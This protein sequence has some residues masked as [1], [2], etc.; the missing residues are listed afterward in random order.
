VLTGE[1]ASLARELHASGG[2][3]VAGIAR[4]LGISRSTLYRYLE[5]RELASSWRLTRATV[6]HQRLVLACD[7]SRVGQCSVMPTYSSTSRWS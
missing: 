2:Y 5:V 1:Q 3:S 6:G 7:R 4:R